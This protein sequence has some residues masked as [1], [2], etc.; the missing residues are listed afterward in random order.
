MSKCELPT[1]RMSAT[2]IRAAEHVTI[3]SAEYFAPYFHIDVDPG[4]DPRARRRRS[5]Q[6][7]RRACHCTSC[8][9]PGHNSRSPK[10]PG[11]AVVS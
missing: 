9:Q 2:L 10:C 11:R 5:Q 1:P 3:A 6:G 7:P 8:G 4:P